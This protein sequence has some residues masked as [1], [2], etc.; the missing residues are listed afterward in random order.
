MTYEEVQREIIGIIAENLDTDDAR[1]EPESRL[2]EDLNANSL[3]AVE[4]LWEIEEKFDIEIPHELE[5]SAR[6]VKD[7]A[8]Y[9]FGRVGRQSAGEG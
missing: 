5:K 3:S 9:V 4:I 6:T 7:I 1:I 2:R 8:D